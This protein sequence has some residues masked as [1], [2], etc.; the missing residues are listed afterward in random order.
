MAGA[1]IGL[2]VFDRPVLEALQKLARSGSDLRPAFEHIGEHLKV[3]HM[4]RWAK[5]ESPDGQ[6]WA[7]LS[8]TT[9]ALKKKNADKILVLNGHLRDTLR[10][11]SSSHSL[12]FGTNRIYGAVQQFGAKAGAFGAY[13][14]RA[15]PWGDIP[16]RPY[17]GV[18]AEDETEILAILADHLAVS[19][20]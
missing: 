9:I 10:Y 5:A 19:A 4:D 13:R 6:K 17:L 2:D 1:F 20:T 18:S 12:E 11:Q 16:A 3:S 8:A 14:G 7:P 15:I